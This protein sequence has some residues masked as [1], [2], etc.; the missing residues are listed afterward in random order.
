M[1]R[2][3]AAAILAVS[4][5][6]APPRTSLAGTSETVAQ[7]RALLD[8]NDA[9]AAADLLETALP[10]TAAPDRPALLEVLRRAY[11]SAARQAEAVG[12]TDEAEYYRENLAILQRKPRTAPSP[13]PATPPK[14]VVSPRPA[15][16][17]EAAPLDVMLPRA[18]LSPER[19]APPAAAP[20]P[21]EAPAVAAPVSEPTEPPPVARAAAA[22]KAP[23]LSG[24]APAEAPAASAAAEPPANDFGTQIK[25]ANI[26]FKGKQ[27]EEAGR[28]YGALAREN[29]LPKEYSS[30]WAYCRCVEVVKQINA[31]PTTAEAWAQIDAEIAK[32]AE[33]SPKLWVVDYLRKLAA[34]RS[35][36]VNRTQANKVIVRGAAPEEP[37]GA[38]LA[39]NGPGGAGQPAP[40]AQPGTPRRTPRPG[41]GNAPAQAQARP[42]EGSRWQV[43]ETASFRIFHSDAELAQRVATVAERTREEQNKRWA[44]SSPRET[45]SP[46]CDIYLYPSAK[47]FSAMT[48]QPEDSPGFSTMGMDRGRINCRRVNLRADHPKITVAILPHEV[49][50]VVLADFFP[51]K[52]IPRWADEGM[53]VLAEPRAEQRLRAAD[54]D[55]PLSSGKLFRM[56][57]LMVMDYP[58]AE[59]WALYYAQSVSLTRFLVE[60]GTPAQ[61]IEFIQGCQQRTHEDELRRIYK[62]DGFAELER[63]W[64]EFAKTQMASASATADNTKKDV[65]TASR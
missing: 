1:H 19:S 11:E 47:I 33:L 61:F 46:K 49:T 35:K 34:E 7:A 22:D 50:H 43:H 8:R 59:H 55:A 44:G 64:L 25:A 12:K 57:D 39:A 17:P 41:G 36:G 6:Y 65:D 51:Q 52:Q 62:I 10:S 38:V 28:I 14:P 48:G 4:L 27:Y 40:G 37:R 5:A 13:A 30:H 56:G 9:K 42:A 24:P 29:R 53:A 60:Q 18:N 58:N 20:A 31:K 21:V 15:A 26:A 32:I 23:E 16:A 45:W 2:L 63:R 3:L 54:L